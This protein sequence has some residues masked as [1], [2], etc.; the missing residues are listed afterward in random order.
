MHSIGEQCSRSCALSL[1][2]QD[3]SFYS[4]AFCPT[5]RVSPGQ[6][7]SNVWILERKPGLLQSHYSAHAGTP[8]V[9]PSVLLIQVCLSD[10]LVLLVM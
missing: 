1:G 8:S 9:W 6:A 7:L 4:R 10:P 2:S 5:W 3:F